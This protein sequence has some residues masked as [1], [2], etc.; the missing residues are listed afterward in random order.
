MPVKVEEEGGAAPQS[1]F[2]LA[3]IMRVCTGVRVG[4]AKDCGNLVKHNVSFEEA[5]T[6]FGDPLGRIVADPRHSTTEERFV[7]LGISRER[8]LLA[9]IVRP[10]CR[11]SSNH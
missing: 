2:R 1:N 5:A 3:S 4:S 6:G 7:L 10:T 8:R 11:G 9:V